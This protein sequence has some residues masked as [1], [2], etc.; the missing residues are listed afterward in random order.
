MSPE[1]DIEKVRLLAQLNGLVIPEDDL[2]S[3]TEALKDCLETLSVLDD[4][5]V[6]PELPGGIRAEYLLK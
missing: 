4:A 3:V 2:E 6:G 5:D 1:L